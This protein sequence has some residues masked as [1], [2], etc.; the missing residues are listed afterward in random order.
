MLDWLTTQLGFSIVVMLVAIGVM[1][2]CVAYFIFFERKISAWMQ[3]RC[4][5]NRVGP[6]GY[7]QPIADGLKMFLK[8]D[9][10]PASVDRGL[11]LLA[12]AL[13][14]FVALIGFAVIPWGGYVEFA[15]GNVVLAQVASVDIGLL[16]I[17][18]ITSLGVYGVVLGGWSGNNKYS[19]YGS[20]RAAAQMLSYEIPLGLAIVVVVM[21]SGELRLERIV[22]QQ[23]AGLWN[24]CYYPLAFVLLL[25]TAFAE[26][27]RAPFD[28]AECEQE[29]IGGFHTE[30]SAMKFGMFFFGEYLHMITNSALMIAL[31]FGGYHLPWIP[32]CQPEDM[33]LLGVVVKTAVYAGKVLAFIFFYMWIRWT[34]PRFRYD[35]LMRL[36]WKGLV[37]AGLLVMVLAGALVYYQRPL[38]WWATVGNVVIIVLL[39][40]HQAV[41]RTPVTGRQLDLPEAP[42]TGTGGSVS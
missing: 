36:A 23:A 24:V 38:S 16:C 29:I 35:Q 39:V 30:Y 32:W 26:T 31:F 7:F 27:N 34:I 22:E 12:P 5:P 41:S 11:F 15:N 18:A 4:G 8:E 3:D 6:A 2:G 9:I 1:M 14:F 33:S 17:V 28:L 20:M 19:F 40:L 13:A 25:I 37:P 42:A 10:I 21:A